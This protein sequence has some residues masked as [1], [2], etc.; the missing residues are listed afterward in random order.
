MLSPLRLKVAAIPAS[1]ALIDRTLLNLHTS[2]EEA[3]FDDLVEM[4]LAAAVEWAEGFMHRTIISRAHEWTLRDFPRYGRQEI[5]LPRGKTQSVEQIVYARNGSTT[6]LTGPSSGSPADAD[7]QEQLDG[8]DGGLLMPPRGSD[9]PTTDD[10]VP[11]PV[12][13]H[14]T[15][16]WAAADVPV[17][18][19]HAVAMYVADAFENRG[20]AESDGSMLSRR[21][22]LLSGWSLPRLY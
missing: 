16:G 20:D 15:A 6:T 3:D 13:V 8:D 17:Q 21:Q 10:D 1:P 14:F 2:L 11:A 18:I 22:A 9:W 5:R 12:V 4:Y 19:K 7:W